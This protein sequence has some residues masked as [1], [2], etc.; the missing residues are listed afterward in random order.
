MNSPETMPTRTMRAGHAAKLMLLQRVG[1]A[2]GDD[3]LTQLQPVLL[4]YELLRVTL[5]RNE[6][7]IEAL[8]AQVERIK[9][10]VHSAMSVSAAA[11]ELLLPLAGATTPSADLAAE[12]AVLLRPEFELSGLRIELVS[13]GKAFP[14][15]RAQGRTMICAALAHAG[16]HADRPAGIL[17]KLKHG[18]DLCEVRVSCR[19]VT[20]ACAA[21]FLKPQQPALS[22]DDL[23]A[24]AELERAVIRREGSGTIVLELPASAQR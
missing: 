23:L 18:E 21:D 9:P 24:L 14:I 20:G 16:D 12:C 4:I 19:R 3:L 13:E 1:G 2:V 7:D 10:A 11:V 15:D 5:A 8:R 22:W 17:V 6:A